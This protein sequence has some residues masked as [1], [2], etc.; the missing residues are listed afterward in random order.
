MVLEVLVE[1]LQLRNVLGVLDL[2]I[3]ENLQVLL[4]LGRV[5]ILQAN[6]DA[7]FGLPGGVARGPSLHGPCQPRP[8]ISP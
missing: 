5:S 2:Q 3:L 6:S 8:C 4:E 1:L 7:T